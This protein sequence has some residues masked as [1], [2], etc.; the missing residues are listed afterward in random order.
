MAFAN[1]GVTFWHSVVIGKMAASSLFLNLAARMLD[2]LNHPSTAK[3]TPTCSPVKLTSTFILE[4]SLRRCYWAIYTFDGSSSAQ[5]S[6]AFIMPRLTQIEAFER[7]KE[8][9]RTGHNVEELCD[10]ALWCLEGLEDTDLLPLAELHEGASV[11][12]D[13]IRDQLRTVSPLTSILSQNPANVTE[14]ITE[15]PSSTNYLGGVNL[16]HALIELVDIFG[17]LVPFNNK[18]HLASLKTGHSYRNQSL[19]TSNPDMSTGISHESVEYNP[20]EAFILY[21]EH[22]QYTSLDVK[23]RKWASRAPADVLSVLVPFVVN[24]ADV[25]NDSENRLSND[26]TLRRLL[27]KCDGSFGASVFF[28]TWLFYYGCLCMLNRDRM[29]MYM[30]MQEDEDGHNREKT[31]T[32]QPFVESDLALKCRQSYIVAKRSALLMATTLCAIHDY[33]PEFSKRWTGP[34]MLATFHA[35][36]ILI[37]LQNESRQKVKNGGFLQFFN[38]DHLAV[39]NEDVQDDVYLERVGILGVVVPRISRSA[40]VQTADLP[41]AMPEIDSNLVKVAAYNRCI[42]ATM[43]VLECM[44]QYW[45]PA[46]F[47]LKNL[48]ALLPAALQEPKEASL[49]RH[50]AQVSTSV[51][52]NLDS[53]S[54]QKSDPVASAINRFPSLSDTT[55]I[56]TAQGFDTNATFFDNH[57][58][59]IQGHAT[60][61]GVNQQSEQKS[62]NGAVPLASNCEEQAS[63]PPIPPSKVLQP[64]NTTSPLTGIPSMMPRSVPKDEML[65]IIH[66]SPAHIASLVVKNADGEDGAEMLERLQVW[67]PFRH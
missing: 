35:C 9:L 1:F 12:G 53:S 56:G 29:V 15:M 60:G 34:S 14:S 38:V 37:M 26:E 27:T 61:K 33:K 11:V 5:N 30:K 66:S 58:R 39:S 45:L 18:A 13:K 8:G 40:S 51:I 41:R 17:E 36:L 16:R 10:E 20:E 4:E 43:K 55:D 52:S 25:N 63:F 2:F 49:S 64:P 32:K 44:A 19:R 67:T 3:P 7:S 22:Q 65:D 42:S 50:A 28:E 21:D 62:K 48:E 46:T 54:R 24:L 23:L 6:K 31:N 59:Y 57:G 47:I